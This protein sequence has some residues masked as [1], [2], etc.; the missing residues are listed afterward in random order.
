MLKRKKKQG[1]ESKIYLRGISDHTSLLQMRSPLRSHGTT[2][3]GCKKNAEKYKK[4]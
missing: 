4:E 3:T 2:L 1:G